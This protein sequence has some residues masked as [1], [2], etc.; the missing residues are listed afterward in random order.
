MKAAGRTVSRSVWLV[1][2]FCSLLL[3]LLLLLLGAWPECAAG[4]DAGIDRHVDE[5]RPAATQGSPATPH[6]TFLQPLA[7]V[8]Q[9]HVDLRWTLDDPIYITYT[10]MRDGTEIARF[11]T[12]VTFYRDTDVTK[13]QT[14]T[15][16]MCRKMTGGGWGC[17]LTQQATVG[18]IHGQLYEDR[19]W[20]ADRYNISGG[21]TLREGATLHI[22]FGA[23]LAAGGVSASI[24]DSQ[25]AVQIF[26][27]WV[28]VPLY[29]GGGLS[30]IQASTVG[31]Y[32][33]K[34][35]LTS[36]AGTLFAGNTFTSS[37]LIVSGLPPFPIEV[38]D[39]AFHASSLWVRGDADVDIN[40]NRFEAQSPIWME[41]R[42]QGVIEGN[43]FLNSDILLATSK[44]VAVR[45]N[46]MRQILSGPSSGRA[47]IVKP[48][49]PAAIEENLIQGVKVHGQHCGYGIEFSGSAEPAQLVSIRNNVIAQW[50]RGIFVPGILQLQVEIRGNTITDN[51]HGIDIWADPAVSV[52]GN[53]IA[54]NTYWSGAYGGLTTHSRT[55]TLD[56]TG[57]YWGHPSGPTHPDNPG[58]Q[59][60]RI[61]EFDGDGNP[62]PGLVDYSGWLASHECRIIDL[63]IAGLEVVQVIQDLNNTVPLVGGKP[64]VVRVYAD[65]G[66]GGVVGNVP[67]ELKAYRGPSLL[68]TM[69][70]TVTAQPVT[71][72][73]AVRADG[74]GGLLFPLEGNW[75]SGT[76]TLTVEIDPGHA[77][78][79]TTHDNNMVSST[80]EFADWRGLR[81]NYL[82]VRYQP[83][84]EEDA[85]EPRRRNILD[86]HWLVKKMLPYSTV[87]VN[88]LPAFYLDRSL[89]PSALGPFKYDFRNAKR[90]LKALQW[91][92]FGLGSERVPVAV[93]GPLV[94]VL[95]AGSLPVESTF[96]G[97]TVAYGL[98]TS[99]SQATGRALGL[100][101]PKAP[102][103]CGLPWKDSGWPYSDATIQEYGYDYTQ[104]EVVPPDAWDL[105]SW[106]APQWISP[107]H[108]GQIHS[109]EW[110]YSSKDL[111]RS[112]SPAEQTY[113]VA[114]GLVYTDGVV[115]F[116]PF[117]QVSSDQPLGSLPPDGF[118]YC[119]E[120]RDAGDVVLEGHCFN[121]DFHN[122]ITGGEANV[123][124]FFVALPLDPAGAR[125]VLRQGD[126]ALG[127]V[128][129]SAHPPTVTVVAPNGGE[130]LG[131]S[132][133]VE[134]N[135]DDDDGTESAYNLWYSMDD[136][137]SWSPLI[138][139]ITG[140]TTFDLD[141]SLAPGGTACRVRV[142]ASDGFHTASD[143]TDGTF[144]VPLK[145]PWA[146]ISL[147]GAGAVVTPPLT[148]DGGAYDP[149][150]GELEGEALVWTSDRDG[151]LGTGSTVWDVDLS[152]G[153][154]RL[155]LTATDS[156]T[157]A[158][159]DTVT[160]TVPQAIAGLVAV[161]NSPTLIGQP[162]T[163]TAT[164][165]AGTSISY[166]WALGDDTMD[167]GPVV[168]HTYL[169]A[170]TYRV[171]VTAS[172]SVNLVTTGTTVEVT[173]PKLYVYLPLVLR[174]SP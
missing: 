33:A 115:S 13:G 46:T 102:I 165:T 4:Q 155:T 87:D 119:L 106:C 164:V 45:H 101:L 74:E 143:E 67:V 104:G 25:G 124:L 113:L 75:L 26:G 126:T 147:P 53:C 19:V 38:S 131:D 34:V 97:D 69:D 36:W 50:E 145:A 168:V 72:W 76:L 174:Q 96:G 43:L 162:T 29:L 112:S 8:G 22:G 109:S 93:V 20:S 116:L 130:I 137:A 79:E 159:S 5:P 171:L 10:I 21:I 151:L 156:Q 86:Q 152:P 160:V 103:P 122:P 154:H 110:G 17:G 98:E 170:G 23:I 141:L 27:A 142:D 49:S 91:I 57:N 173:V 108:Y 169:E 146:V 85:E 100:K 167:H 117:W 41:G 3:V 65:S 1:L 144:S 35:E 153:Q 89:D 68:G 39:N 129:A 18:E 71:D 60:D 99:L 40:N 56:A 30:A 64:T 37:Q 158:S 114:S 59:G 121:L 166:T 107:Y 123:D 77:I 133:T 2:S 157:L 66:L 80:L 84:P 135:G 42:T 83:D 90:F 128:D 78:S 47:V 44:P 139:D 118:E 54:G 88:V 111:Q 70:G 95:P 161:N 31:P 12:D 61:N 136:G 73:D 9:D 48:H 92:R 28:E 81:I 51:R 125:V 127:Q 52:Q 11:G 134:W 14:Y 63:S 105:M 58:D 15:Y 6:N 150:E 132:V 120:L 94:A 55:A 62:A 140:T 16:H 24:A 163:L 148:L 149:E 172:N 138:M 7:F 82:P 32:P